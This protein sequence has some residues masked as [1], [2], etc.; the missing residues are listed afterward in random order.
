MEKD[1]V[2]PFVIDPYIP[3]E[4]IV[5][6]WAGTS[7]GKS[8]V[9]WAMAS[10]I[11]SG[12]S[13][14]GLPTQK[15]RVLYIELDTPKPVFKPR[16]RKL[17]AAPD[18]WWL[19]MKPLG[20]P[21]IGKEDLS[22]LREAAL[23]INPDVVFIDTLRKAHVYDDKDSLAPRMVYG[24]FQEIFPRSALVFISHTKKAPINPNHIENVKEN[25]SGSN[26]FLD[27]AQVGLRLE[28]Y[29][30]RGSKENLRL[31]HQKAQVSERLKPLPLILA[32]DGSHLSSPLFDELLAAYTLL[33]ETEEVEKGTLD[34]ML[35]GMVDVSERTARKRRRSVEEG[36]FPASRLF[37]SPLGDEEHSEEEGE[38]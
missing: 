24:T 27:D 29:R 37:L 15:G 36:H 23:K 18:V 9:S 34:K 25:F 30:R 22:V 13:F 2:V 5:F 17:K 11:G 12:T 26:H 16:V 3:R 21:S 28:E 32:K 31:H 4:G 7:V 14:F 6:F 19:F 1:E 20:V 10:S 35:A 38:E 33:N 8:P